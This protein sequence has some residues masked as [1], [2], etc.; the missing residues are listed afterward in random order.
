M[1]RPLMVP[2][3]LALTLGT[4]VLVGCDTGRVN[5]VHTRVEAVSDLTTTGKPEVQYQA[6]AAG[7]PPVPGSPTA[8][9]KDG[10]QPANDSQARVSPGA[11]EGA[12]M[13]VTRQPKD[14]F[15]RQ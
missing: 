8:A 10:R 3:T 5:K 4:L 14:P 1:K 6:D 9:G 7:I 15:Q 13:A 2:A 11:E 12:P